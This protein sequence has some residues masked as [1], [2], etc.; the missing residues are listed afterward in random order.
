M[1]L[2]TYVCVN[3][4][5]CFFDYS[6]YLYNYTCVLLYVHM[7]V[8]LCMLYYPILSYPIPSFPAQSNPILSYTI[9]SIVYNAM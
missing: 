4:S 8:C 7:S 9:L 3:L 6:S 1:H 2:C 5:L